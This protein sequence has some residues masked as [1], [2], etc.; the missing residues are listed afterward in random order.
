MCHDHDRPGPDWQ[1]S[2]PLFNS[3]RCCMALPR[4]PKF[5]KEQSLIVYGSKHR[6]AAVNTW[7]LR[8]YGQSKAVR[9]L[10]NRGAIAYQAEPLAQEVAIH[11]F[12]QLTQEYQAYIDGRKKSSSP[13]NP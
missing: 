13:L 6:D 4:K 12:E 2:Q 11:E 7:A 8:L 9:D 1:L 3:R 5:V 10:L